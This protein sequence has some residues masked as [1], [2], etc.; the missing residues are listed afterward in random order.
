MSLAV[1]SWLGRVHGGILCELLLLDANGDFSAVDWETRAQIK[2]VK[3]VAA[4][5]VTRK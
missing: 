4:G 1:C 2:I 5:S 3:D